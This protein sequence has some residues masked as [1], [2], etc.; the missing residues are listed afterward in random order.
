MCPH[1]SKYIRELRKKLLNRGPQ[2]GRYSEQELDNLIREYQEALRGGLITRDLKRVMQRMEARISVAETVMLAAQAIVL[3]AETTV[4]DSRNSRLG[5][6][7]GNFS[8][9]NNRFRV[10]NGRFGCC[11]Q[12]FSC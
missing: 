11:H 9:R 10:R 7:N 6:Q 1:R 2:G 8:N 4:L 3:A 12:N 5:C